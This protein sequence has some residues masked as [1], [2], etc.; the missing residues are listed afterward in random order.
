MA[1]G[2]TLQPAPTCHC[3]ECFDPHTEDFPRVFECTA[4]ERD[5]PWCR[6][7]SDDY[8]DLCDNCWGLVVKMEGEI[9][10]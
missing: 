8:P 1:N 10:R 5:V 7:A 3:Q 6:G 2:Y 4:C 9:E